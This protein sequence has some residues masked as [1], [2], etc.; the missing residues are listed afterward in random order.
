MPEHTLN[1][2]SSLQC[3]H[4]G[5]VLIVPAN[6]RAKARRVA[7]VTV[8]DSFSVV[9]CP[10]QL[11]TAPPTPSPCISVQWIVTDSHVKAARASTLSEASQGLC[12]NA[13]QAP[14][15][16]VTIAAGQSKVASR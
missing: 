4:G 3:P 7:I 14:Q 9:G 11:P 10:F 15:G 13:Q 6:A 12:Y 16:P 2:Q 5:T 1:I 8:N